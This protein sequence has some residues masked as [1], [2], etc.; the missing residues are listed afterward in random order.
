M[1]KYLL[2][3]GLAVAVCLC[4]FSTTRAAVATDG[5]LAVVI[6]ME[7]TGQVQVS[8]T[9]NYRNPSQLSW[10]I[11]SAYQD[12]NVQNQGASVSFSSQ[13]GGDHTLITSASPSKSWVLTYT[14]VDNLIRH[15]DQDQ[16]FF[17]IFEEPGLNLAD[18]NVSFNLP[19]G[20][21]PDKGLTS[22]VYAINGVAEAKLVGSSSQSVSYHL[23]YAGPKALLT[24]SATWP[25]SFL[26]LTRYQ[27]L[28]LTLSNLEL[29]PWIVL[30]G[31]LP[32]LGLLAFGDLLWKS[33]KATRQVSEIIDRPPEEISPMLV[34]V[35]VNKKIS[36]EE[37]AAVIIDLCSRG[38]LVI[39]HKN[40]GYYLGQRKPFDENLQPWEKLFLEQLLAGT[41]GKISA[42]N[43]TDLASQSLYSPAI[44]QAFSD[45]YQII[46]DKTYF[47][48]NPHL[49]RIRYKLVAL[50]IYFAGIAGAIW[51]AATD[52]S[53]YLLIPLAGTVL[54]A[55]LIMHFSSELINYSADG[56]AA[57]NKWRAFANYLKNN[58]PYP[59]KSTTDQTFQRYLAY[60]MAMHATQDWAG[61]FEKA[62][63][64]TLRPD[65][66]ISYQE[67]SQT[68]F[69]H[70]LEEFTQSLSQVVDHM[71]GP[72]VS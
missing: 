35:L 64:M 51:L 47:K 36:K 34:G 58:Q 14:S 60:A 69:V 41:D 8:E 7:K 30:G 59:V 56:L 26:S 18:I 15:N 54:L 32:L 61:R 31:L 11:Q 55:W 37:I 42:D 66:F 52:S 40:S 53:P 39:V 5:T 49:T 33:K 22:N 29:I 13:N 1:S 9:I 67:Q 27:E 62:N 20:T 2:G 45:V 65:W 16:L 38:Y 63:R 44:R 71:R 70:E 43:L 4:P 57:L 68:Q 3:F 23:D 6:N 10:I 72:S 12:L 24:F 25:K 28:K 50:F 17:K 21:Y 19:P 48:E 46:S